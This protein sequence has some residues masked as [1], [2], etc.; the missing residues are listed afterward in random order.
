MYQTSAPR[1]SVFGLNPVPASI[2]NAA[3]A[4]SSIGLDA[5]SD[6]FVVDDTGKLVPPVYV[7][8]QAEAPNHPKRFRKPVP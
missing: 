3:F 4:R 2:V 6:H 5:A 1:S 8:P 7:V